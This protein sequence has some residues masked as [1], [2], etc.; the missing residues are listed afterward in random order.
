MALD[1]VA[2]DIIIDETT[3]IQVE[4]DDVNPLDSPHSTDPTLLYLLSLNDTGGLTSPEVAF[5]EDFVVA[6]AS[7]GETITSVVLA[8]NSSGTPFSTT[9]GVNSGIQTVDGNYVWLFQD[10]TDPNV[11]IGVIGTSDP[12]VEPAETGP[13]AFSFALIPTS[14]TNADLY[15]VEYV[16]LLHPNVNNPDDRI[17]LTDQVFASVTGTSVVNFSQLGDAPPGHNNW[18]I[19]DAD[20]ASPQKILVTAHDNGVQ[21]E[22]NISTQGLGV[23]S[24]DVRFGRELQIDLISGGTQSAGKNFTNTPTAPDYDTHIENVSGAGFSVSQSTP[25]NTVADIEIHAYNN[26]DNAEGANF[27][28]DDNDAE[29]NITGVTF[30]LN[31]VATTAAA[32]GITVDLSGNG[33]ILQDVGEGVTVDFT[34]AGG[35]GGT[36]DRFTIK[37]IDTEKDY[38]DVKEVHFS[39]AVANA[40]NEEVGS[41]I[42]FDDDG[43]SIT[44]IGVPPELTVDESNL[45]VDDSA[46]FSTFFSS[47]AGADGDAISYALGISQGT[48]DSGLTD[49]ATGQSVLLFVE[50]GNVVGR[51]GS[52]AG[53][54]VFTVSVSAAGVVSLDQARAVVHADINNPDDSRT[55][56]AADL[57]TLT[58]TITDNDGDAASATHNIGQNL[59][60]EDDGPTI[61][62]TGT[63]PTLTVDETVLGTDVTQSFAANFSSAFG[64]DGAGT[65]TYALGLTAGSTGIVDTATGEAVVL[66]LNGG[67][68]EGRTATTNA[69]VFTVSVSAAGSVTLDQIRA[70]IHANPNDPD[71]STTLAADNLVQLTATITDKDGDD[72]SATLNIGQNLNFEDDG[73]TITKPFDGD[74]NAGNGNGTHET[75]ANT[76]NASATGAFGYDI[77]AD[78]H[79][80]AFY[81]GGG[82]DFVDQN[83]ALAGVQIGLSGTIIGG[84]GGNVLTPNVTLASESLT[85]ATFN[86][87]FTYDRDPAA[88]VQTGTAGGTL[89]FDK[90]ADTYTINLTDP[91]EGFSFD[92]IHTS[93][94]LSKEPTSNT[95]HPPIV[96]E[97]LQADDPNT[98][99]DEDFYVQFTG[100]AINNANPSFS[101]TNNGEGSSADSTFNGVP[102][103]EMVSNNNETWVSATQS[104]NGVAGDTIQKGELL[105][106]RFFNSNVGI[107]AEA[108]TPTA[109]AGT[110]AIKFDGI[111]NS[112]DLMLILDL[113]DKNGADNIAG[114]ADDNS[115]I[116]R[117]VYVSN[118]DIFKTGQVPAPYSSEFT[119]D[120]ND[121]LVIIEQNDYNAAGEDYVMQGAQIMQSGNGI[122]GTAIDLTRATGAGGGSNATT[123][124]VAFDATDNDVLKITDIGFTT[125]V[126]QTPD[127]NL[128]FAFQVE[129]ADADQTAIQH[130]LVDV[131]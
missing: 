53:P 79:T 98:P 84:G 128:D 50:G 124:L 127:A 19:L 125:T 116:T 38:F 126:T 96:V 91:L 34:T 17:D 117:A 35:A 118:A 119:L 88:G 15:T 130:I 107:A 20:A 121:G 108:T 102:P 16:P 109:T 52:A 85:S 70:V 59:N 97:R 99:D 123:N 28:G 4:D 13:L 29:I 55:L 92:V 120:N 36:F 18:Y 72:E 101:L 86:F 81:T 22:V 63:E 10:P 113:I 105:T 54:I 45:S 56:A 43:P 129:D 23:A 11:V 67:V 62:T 33:L 64:A 75:L 46:D 39:G 25:T 40:H 32:L 73:P 12:T 69:L 94:L 24:Q 49:T 93:E 83:G 111:G 26:N 44:A 21:S 51:A 90:V 95:G 66:S 65:L 9:V 82:S 131:A 89:V 14:A 80:A 37:N 42:N 57:V 104:T 77:G 3:G 60:F 61:T 100:N 30:K 6:S 1:I 8:Q 103:H 47:N 27:P 31:G 115:T 112:E 68:V 74:Q 78:A 71:D 2:Q 58:A 41:F 110:M 76:L 87:T 106:L 5:K 7:A 48:N 114:T 122:T